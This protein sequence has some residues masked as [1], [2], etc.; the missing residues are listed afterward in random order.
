MAKAR[1]PA[2]APLAR[3][4]EPARAWFEASLGAPTRAQALAWE[5]IA[6]GRSALLSA[7]TGSGKTLAA[8]FH[9]IDRLGRAPEPPPKRRCKVVYVSPLKALAVDVEKNLRA[10]LSGVALQAS[11]RGEPFRALDV[12]V[13][14]G[15]TPQKARAQAR[16]HPP[17]VL[18]TTPE[19]LYLL[20]TGRDK[21]LLAGVETVIVDEIHQLVPSKRGAHL[22]LSL[23][24][25]EALRDAGLPP[26]QRVGLSATQKPLDEVARLLGGH[27]GERYR[28]VAVLDASEPKRL[29]LTVELPEVDLGALRDREARGD[30]EPGAGPAGTVWPHL[31]RHVLEL[32]RAHRSTLVF[33]NSRRLAERLAAALNELAGE[34][35]V[36]AH[37]GSVSKE[38]RA[39]LEDRLKAGTLPA[40]VATSSLELGIDMGAVDLVVQIEAPPSVASGMQRV[41]RASHGVGQVSRGVLVPKHRADLLAAAAAAAGVREGDVEPTRYPRLPLDVL[42]Q[43][44]VAAVAG[45]LDAASPEGGPVEADA[46]YRAVKRAAPF[47]DLSRGAFDGVLDLLTGRYPS[48]AFA[49]LRPRLVWDRATDTLEP[50][51]GA[52]RL[53]ILNGGTIPDRGLYGVFLPGEPG[54]GGRAQRLGEL[55]EEMVFELREGEVFLLGASSWR[56]DEI[57]R[58]RVVVTPAP[59]QPGKM[60]FWHG[61]RAGRDR[62]FGARI[63]ALARALDGASDEAALARLEADG[64]DGPARTNLLAYV[65]GQREAGVVPTD[66]RIVVEV[67]RDELGD[68]RVCV[69]SPYGTRVHAP[70]A[71]A[72]LARLR[73]A[74]LGEVDVVYSDDGLVFRLPGAD[75]P[76]DR[77]LFFPDAAEV[78][79]LVAHELSG[80][81][82]FAA[83]FR[84]AA[85]RALLLPRRSPTKRSPL[86]M[87]RKRATDLLAVASE[88]PSFP[89]L[90]EAYRECLSDVFDLA[91]LEELLARVARRD[92]AVE[93]V[94]NDVPSPF[95]ASLLFSFAGNFLYDGD[96]P[97][98]ERRAQALTVD[99]TLLA[100]LLGPRALRDLLDPEVLERLEDE[101]Q[102][103]ARPAASADALT[104][105]LRAVGDLSVEEIGERVTPPEAAG[106]FVDALVAARRAV[107]VRVAGA[108]RYVVPEDA[109]R[110]RDGLGVALPPGLPSALL[111]ARPDALR[112]LV[113]RYARTHGPFRAR[114]VATRFAAPLASVDRALDTLVAEGKLVE[115][116][117]LRDDAGVRELCDKEHLATIRRRTLARLRDAVEPVDDL[118][119]ARFSLAWHGVRAEP[120]ATPRG[121]ASFHAT[122]PR[123]GRSD[124]RVLVDLVAAVERLSGAPLPL[125]DLESVVLPARVPGYRPHHL[126]RLLAQGDVVWAGLEPIGA[127]DGRVALYLPDDELAFATPDLAA[128]AAGARGTDV[129]EASLRAALGLDE[130]EARTV[131]LLAR[132][133]ALFGGDVARALGGFPGDRH[134]TL[135]RLVWKGL[136]TN[137]TLA[138]LRALSAERR[139]EAR[140]RPGAALGR[141]RARAGG[142]GDGRWSLRWARW[143]DVP[144][145]TT[146]LAAAARVVLERHGVLLREAL[147][148][149]AVPG[150]RA[151]FGVLYPV[152]RALEDAGRARRGHFVAGRGALQFARPGADDRLR[153]RPGDADLPGAPLVLAATDPANPYGAALPWPAFAE[154][155]AR[156]QR[157]AGARVVFDD[158]RLVAFV[159]RGGSDVTTFP[160]DDPLGQARADDAVA[161]ALARALGGARR[162]VTVTRVDGAPADAAP[163]GAALRARGFLPRAAGL[164][165]H[166]ARPAPG[167]GARG[168]GDAPPRRGREA[169]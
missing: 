146:R 53:A 111:E 44:V 9:A 78:S 39:A 81:A 85:A 23:E 55:D 156:P 128:A 29:A 48:D 132:R 144:D 79:A 50:R 136:V 52:K 74:R 65:R 90:A 139:A 135:L 80:S 142:T 88:H 166:A 153:A 117:F 137:D 112:G 89:I 161:L 15:D 30:A 12:L 7:P 141:G 40:L 108:V 36:F 107:P 93:V 127:A 91:G 66:R 13:R 77:S 16:R 62:G 164:V 49:D 122:P 58:D 149:E 14:T 95:A 35:L 60:P 6:A 168:L 133:G 10:P 163:L 155:A 72:V 169:P 46:V 76:P 123:E 165:L 92:V 126:D 1:P 98:A 3:F 119:F 110:Y 124:E 45:G 97:L 43:Q 167:D 57:T 69:L 64:L 47:V 54:A 103:R 41:G 104:D 160:Q 100:E 157:A 26:L 86:W 145:E 33:V 102:R 150:A 5:A 118:A 63:G 75:E 96:A 105:V 27:D 25:L 22:F 67:T 56:V 59:G 116:A 131:A 114:D 42:A 32:V 19:S 61:D 162:A 125:S 151:G 4:S 121:A 152:L 101:L 68:F 82:L 158:G 94:E 20:L 8:F 18:V 148:T 113:H 71:L 120:P 138:P 70:W 140:T 154:K 21:E 147:G 87:Q 73:E 84:E 129:D 134:A 28:D 106:A 37:H 2:S 83:R 17:D 31:H 109:A 115:G 11:A 38:T 143:H 34:E 99:P 24:R 130:D 51:P 159:A